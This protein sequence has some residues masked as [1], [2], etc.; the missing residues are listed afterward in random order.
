M[1]GF[2][3]ILCTSILWL[4]K[5]K[6]RFITLTESVTA[7]L[8]NISEEVF[9]IIRV[10]LVFILVLLLQTQ[11]FMYKIFGYMVFEYDYLLG[12]FDV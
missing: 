9:S 12:C 1:S 5:Q 7:P 3:L 6:R 8:E 4:S 10:G 2:L 11:I